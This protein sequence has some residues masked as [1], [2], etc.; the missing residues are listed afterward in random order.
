MEFIRTLRQKHQT[1]RQADIQK[2][3]Q[4]VITIED[5]DNSLYIAYNGTPFVPINTEWK[6]E[7]IIHQL[8]LLRQNYVNAKMKQNGLEQITSVF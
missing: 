8:S 3:A 6:T 4:E 1:Q 2:Q 5:F 7:E